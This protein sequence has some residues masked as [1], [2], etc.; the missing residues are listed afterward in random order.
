MLLKLARNSLVNRRY[1]VLLTVVS[2]AISVAL[3]LGIEHIRREAKSSFGNTL[4]GTDLI[5]GAR[6][7]SINLLL[8]TVFHTGYP[9]N[10]ISWESYQAIA[11]HRSVK[12]TIP[13]SLGDSH[14]GYRV[15]GT[16]PALFEH[17]R[18]GQRQALSFVEGQPFDQRFDVVLGAE[19]ARKLGYEVGDSLIIAHGLGAT[20][21]KQHDDSPFRVVGIL[22]ATGTPVDRALYVSLAGIEAIHAGWQTGIPTHQEQSASLDVQP[23]SISGVLVG[24]TSRMATFVMQ[25]YINDFKAEPLMA[26]LPGVALSE[27][28]QM[29]AMVERLLWLISVLVL[30]A[31]M[32]GMVTMLLAS[33]KERS[34]ELMVLRAVGAPGWVLFVLIQVEVLLITGVAILL[35]IGLLVAGLLVTQPFLAAQFSLFMSANPWHPDTGYLVLGILALA[36]LLAVVPATLAVRQMLA[37]GLSARL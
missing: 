16:T 36:M 17:Y 20:S 9:T 2:L 3:L 35:G 7:G 13:L 10:N 32:V 29:M 4:S 25:R 6:S 11:G 26:I 14:R 24:L 8:Y 1:T 31:A 34:R 22:G 27:L 28:W 19:V 18:Y 37:V 12:W 15:V 21:F 33:M 30:L 23:Q 5:V